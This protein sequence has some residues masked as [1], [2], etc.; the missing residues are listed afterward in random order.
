M[1]IL[2]VVDCVLVLRSFAVSRVIGQ[3]QL[4]ARVGLVAG[5]VFLQLGLAVGLRRFFVGVSSGL[6]A[7]RPAFRVLSDLRLPRS[8]W[9]RSGLLTGMGSASAC[10][11]PFCAVRLDAFYPG[12]LLPCVAGLFWLLLSV[13]FG[14]FGFVGSMCFW[15]FLGSP[16]GVLFW[17]VGVA[18]SG[19]LGWCPLLVVLWC[20]F[21]LLF[22]LLRSCFGFRLC[23]C[24]FLAFWVAWSEASCLL[25][26]LPLRLVGS[27][28][29]ALG[30][31]VGCS[32]LPEILWLGSPAVSFAPVVAVLLLS[33]FLF[34]IVCFLCCG[35]SS[36]LFVGLLVAFV[37]VLTVVRGLLA[38]IV[39][40]VRL[41]MLSLGSVVMFFVLLVA[42]FVADRRVLLPGYWFGGSLFFLV[43]CVRVVF[44]R[45][46]AAPGPAGLLVCGFLACAVLARG[47]W[48]FV[49]S[50]TVGSLW[51]V[52]PH[53]SFAVFFSALLVAFFR[54]VVLRSPCGFPFARLAVLGIV[55]CWSSWVFGDFILYRGSAGFVRFRFAL[56]AC[57]F[58]GFARLLLGWFGL[59][60]FA[61]FGLPDWPAGFVSANVVASHIWVGVLSLFPARVV[62][63]CFER[64]LFFI[65]FHFVGRF[66]F[67]D[68][69][70]CF[71]EMSLGLNVCWFRHVRDFG[72]PSGVFACWYHVVGGVLLVACSPVR[73]CVVAVLLS[74]VGFLVGLP[75][76]MYGCGWIVVGLDDRGPGLSAGL[77]VVWFFVV[78]LV[79]P[80][81]VLASVSIR[82]RP[83]LPLVFSCGCFP[84]VLALT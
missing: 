45:A 60:G 24:V 6:G 58:F 20:L 75:C 9:L 59:F 17:L 2:L 36:W 83:A 49:F 32:A 37:L 61:S 51:W 25:I 22:G 27:R 40:A 26:L 80:W 79:G 56:G 19:A 39:A 31:A 44:S 4:S 28:L 81:V 63:C 53:L 66:L 33:P 1:L 42:R 54:L 74:L 62:S 48:G 5:L 77:L 64:F 12:R 52:S 84:F 14:L 16:L 8:L 13:G 34:F 15:V 3:L 78:A 7:L 10:G 73:G 72:A 21:A 23:F 41:G 55:L 50:A 46:V 67:F 57:A 35:L 47:G 29:V 71:C 65:L 69:G 38:A 43:L 70:A 68:G 82:T 30:V 76:R 11:R 18:V